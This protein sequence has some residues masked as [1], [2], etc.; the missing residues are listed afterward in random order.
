M[1][2]VALVAFRGEG[3]ANRDGT[4]AS[5]H[6]KL[7]YCTEV[8]IAGCTGDLAGYINGRYA[9]SLEEGSVNGRAVFRKV[10]FPP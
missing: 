2:L 4:C 10:R 5:S 3:P 8:E 1:L 7:E 9:V 6:V